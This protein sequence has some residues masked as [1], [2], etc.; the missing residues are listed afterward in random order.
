VIQAEITIDELAR[1]LGEEGLTL[2]DVRGADEYA[3]RLGAPCD[4]R[5]GRI[6]G[7][8]NVDVHELVHLTPGE[9]EARLG[10]GPG[11]EIVAYCHSGHR[12]AV[13]V[14]V[15][16]AAGYEARN[17]TGSWHEWSREP[18]LPGVSDA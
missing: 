11:A 9:L 6:P 17:F 16:R 18:S 4:P 14:Q 5:Q 7:A 2:V 10:V 8:V 12:S 13:A 1:R 3:G 15:L